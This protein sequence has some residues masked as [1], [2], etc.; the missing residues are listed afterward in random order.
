MEL[1]DRDVTLTAPTGGSH[2][3]IIPTTNHLL[4]DALHMQ[5]ILYAMQHPKK[6]PN[7][8]EMERM[9]DTIMQLLKHGKSHEVAGLGSVPTPYLSGTGRILSKDERS[10]RE[11]TDEEAAK[12]LVVMLTEEFKAEIDLKLAPYADFVRLLEREKAKTSKSAQPEH[13]DIVLL[14]VTEKRTVPADKYENHKG[15]NLLFHLASQLV[16]STSNS[17]ERRVKAALSVLQGL[18]DADIPVRF[19]VHTDDDKP[20]GTTLTLLQ[21]V[22]FVLTFV[23]EVWLEKESHILASV[24]DEPVALPDVTAPVKDPTE[25]DVLLGRG[26][27]TN[28][29]PGNRR[30]RDIIALHRPD[31]IRA[32]KMDKPAVARK[33]VKAIRMGKTPGRYVL[34]TDR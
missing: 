28:A 5:H 10:W 11:A 31:Y 7:R 26:G 32:I 25:Y 16:T 12:A 29:W 17:P 30:F 18:D 22:E 33:I 4:Q 21:A 8:K 23:F 34:K 1:G 15:N 3:T 19:V 6:Q 20:T 14:Q 2:G 27:L 9:V 13:K 24:S